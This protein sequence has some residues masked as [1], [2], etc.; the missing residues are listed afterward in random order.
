MSSWAL[1]SYSLCRA[2]LYKPLS[3]PLV[4]LNL[5]QQHYSFSVSE[6]DALGVWVNICFRKR[7]Y[8]A[9][10]SS[11]PPTILP[12]ISRILQGTIGPRWVSKPMHHCYIK[13]VD[14]ALAGNKSA[15]SVVSSV[16][17][18]GYWMVST[19]N[20][21]VKGVTWC[22]YDQ[23]IIHTYHLLFSMLVSRRLQPPD[24]V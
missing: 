15:S 9:T 18:T 24:A 23:C 11:G 1:K 8:S 3:V 14:K 20:R 22:N 4:P 10:T 7:C 19:L 13:A 5:S 2:L 21:D 16:P 17:T 12:Y 6:Q